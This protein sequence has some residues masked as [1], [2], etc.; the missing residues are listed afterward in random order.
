[1]GPI[2]A[3]VHVN[4]L[5]FSLFS[6]LNGLELLSDPIASLTVLN[7]HE[8]DTNLAAVSLSIGVNNIP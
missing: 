1:M 2:Q 3:S 5:G 8:L 4:T 6:E 7:M